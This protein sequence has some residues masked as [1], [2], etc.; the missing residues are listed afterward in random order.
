LGALS[1][2]PM[3]FT[4]GWSVGWYFVPIA[5]LF[6]PY[7]AMK[8]IWQRSHKD[9]SVSSAILGLWWAAWLISYFLSEFAMHAFMGADS[10]T[11]YSSSAMT[12]I[13][14]DGFDVVLNIVALMLVTRI[15]NAYSKNYR[16]R[17]ASTQ[18]DSTAPH[19]GQPYRSKSPALQPS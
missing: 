5:N 6:K 4:P 2:H 18:G 11:E 16:Q 12:Y 9:Q 1:G 13:V 3:S 7:L 15:A 8:E 14:C 19:P 10:V 17:R